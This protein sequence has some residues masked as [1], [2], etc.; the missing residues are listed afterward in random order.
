MESAVVNMVEEGE[1]VLV[2]SNGYFCERLALMA[3]RCGGHVVKLKK[4]WGEVFSFEEIKA[5]L[6]EHSPK[7]VLIKKNNIYF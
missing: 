4:P 2:L 1:K 5:A 7:Y 6:N 3:E